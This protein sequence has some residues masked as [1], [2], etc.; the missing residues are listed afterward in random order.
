MG[1]EDNDINIEGIP[2]Y[3]LPQP[4]REFEMDDSSDEED[5]DEVLTEC[6]EAADDK[7]VTAKVTV[8]VIQIDTL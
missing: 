8:T 7:R 6:E 3:K 4:D 1:T 5:D 2:D